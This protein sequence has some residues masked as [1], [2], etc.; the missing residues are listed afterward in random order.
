MMCVSLCW[1]EGSATQLNNM[2]TKPHYK[3][4]LIGFLGHWFIYSV[5]EII[6][7]IC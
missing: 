4:I 1:L 2:K 7:K 3:D 5:T 6:F